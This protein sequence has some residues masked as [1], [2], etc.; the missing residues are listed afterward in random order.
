MNLKFKHNVYFPHIFYHRVSHHHSHDDYYDDGGF[1]G[2]GGDDDD[3]CD[4]EGYHQ[5]RILSAVRDQ[6]DVAVY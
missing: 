5:L 1:G 3:G 2:G 4:D 6:N